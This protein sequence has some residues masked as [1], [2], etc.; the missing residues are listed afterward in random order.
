MNMTRMKRVALIVLDGVGVGWQDDAEKYGDVGA[1]TLGHV[2]QAEHPDIP[3]LTEL[4][5]LAA[6]GIHDAEEDE[7]IGCYGRMEEKAA[8]KD[9]TTGHW[10][11]AGLTL[12]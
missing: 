10:E 2:I 9:T 5:L 3:N 1:N 11:L 4:G 7:P 8:G 12:D 6:A